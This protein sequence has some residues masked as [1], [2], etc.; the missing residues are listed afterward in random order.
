MRANLLVNVLFAGASLWFL[1][2]SPVD[3]QMTPG[4]QQP[5]FGQMGGRGMPAAQPDMA[6]NTSTRMQSKVDDKKFIRDAALGGMAEVELGKLAQEKASSDAVK[7]FGERM[8]T[9]HTK[10][11]DDLKKLAD[12]ESVS[13]PT[14]LDS[15]H[16]SRIDKLSK[17]SGTD[18]DRAYI[19]DELKDH[20]QDVR[21]FQ[22][23]AQGGS[24]A[25]V[26]DFA[27]KTL[28][29]LQDHLAAVKGLSKVKTA[30]AL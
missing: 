1:S 10:A 3:A 12:A 8:V 2:G 23:E 11:N 16:Q 28:P 18:F 30:S 22:E 14:A 25:S 7:Q 21:E 4:A 20:E 6:T 9:D 17:L 26:K 5:A 24:D 29:T 13:I 15:K 19:K 27:S